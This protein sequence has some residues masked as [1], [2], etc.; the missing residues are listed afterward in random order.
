[1]PNLL[2][3]ALT[4]KVSSSKNI[5]VITTNSFGVNSL[6]DSRTDSLVSFFVSGEMSSWFIAAILTLYIL[7]PLI[8]RTC[9]S[10]DIYILMLL[11]YAG[12]FV[13]SLMATES[14]AVRL[15]NEA[16]IVR[17]P[18][19]LL[20]IRLGYLIKRNQTPCFSHL[21]ICV[22]GGLSLILYVINAKYNPVCTRWAER[23]L[24]LPI[25][26]VM[27][28]VLTFIMDALRDD[29][30]LRKSL[31]FLGG[32]TL[33][34]YLTHEKILLLYNTYIPRCTMGSLLANCSA[35]VIAILLSYGISISVSRLKNTH[36]S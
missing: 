32:I 28:S 21:Q 6:S 29:N 1:M 14:S 23:L 15:V 7:F 26:F 2:A 34:I 27:A 33:E 31:V 22:L 12:S 11:V 20:G 16:F 17:I 10:H 4:L 30:S 9:R 35:V 5:V 25:S 24:F 36:S 19:F 3:T 13:I 8:Y 18:S